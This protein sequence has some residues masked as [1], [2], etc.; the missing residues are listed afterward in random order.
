MGTPDQ[1]PHSQPGFRVWS[2]WR[3]HR[4]RLWPQDRIVGNVWAAPAQICG[5]G[6]TK[7]LL[8]CTL[9]SRDIGPEMIPVSRCPRPYIWAGRV[10]TPVQSPHSQPG[11]RVWSSWRVHR[12][13][14]WPQGGMWAMSGLLQLRSV[15]WD[16]PRTSYTAASTAKIIGPEMIPV[17]RCPRL[18]IRAG[19]MG[20]PDQLPHSQTR[21]RVWS[22]WRVHRSRLWPQGGIMGNV[23]AAPAQ[24]CG[25]GP[26]KDLLHCTLHSRDIGPE[27]IPVSRCPRPY[28]QAGRVG[29]PD[30][31]PHLQTVSRVWSSWCLHQSRLWP[32][33]E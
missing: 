6:P 24:I 12:S 17:S 30:Q 32:Q 1:P 4:S 5:L 10:G 8:H 33:G 15:A 16:P 2:S 23:W 14:L 31:L 19:R 3:V 22:S 28:I 26:T 7:D 18:Y 21:F 11:F 20:T 29:T 9:H 13:H 27:M 25:L